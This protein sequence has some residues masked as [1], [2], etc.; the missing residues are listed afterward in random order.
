[1]WI[2]D[3]KKISTVAKAFM[4]EIEINNAYVMQNHD[5]VDWVQLFDNRNPNA[6]IIL[7]VSKS[8][9]KNVLGYSDTEWNSFPK[10]RPPKTGYYLV[11]LKSKTRTPF[12]TTE[13]YEIDQG[14]S[15][16]LDENVIAFRELP[17]PYDPMPWEEDSEPEEGD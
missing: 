15:A 7:K 6:S 4:N 2:I 10:I 17:G 9:F 16:V 13:F 3:D 8:L 11:T 5:S 14:W 12:V 1:M